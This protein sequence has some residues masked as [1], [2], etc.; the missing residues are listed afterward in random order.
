MR[1]LIELLPYHAP[2]L[3]AVGVMNG[4]SFAAQLD[5]AIERNQRREMKLIDAKPVEPHPAEELKG[6]FARLRRRV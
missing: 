6:P 1:L 5:R 4:D 3:M 2:K